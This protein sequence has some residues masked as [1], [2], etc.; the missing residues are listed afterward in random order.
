MIGL[1][2]S[3]AAEVSGVASTIELAREGLI[4]AFYVMIP[5]VVSAIAASIIVGSLGNRLGAR[6]PQIAAIARAA[7]VVISLIIVGSTIA[8]GLVSFSGDLWIRALVGAGGG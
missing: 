7:A 2:P 4:Y 8:S 5:V 6:D 1:D 3:H